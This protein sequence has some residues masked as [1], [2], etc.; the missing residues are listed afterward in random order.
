MKDFYGELNMAIEQYEKGFLSPRFSVERICDK[1]QWC[2][3]FKK[4]TLEQKNELVD[5]LYNQL[6]KDGL[7]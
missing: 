3:K 4:I 7:L 6:E 5:R 2:F 1:I